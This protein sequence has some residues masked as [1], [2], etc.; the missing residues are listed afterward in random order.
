MC[1]GW[2]RK[3]KTLGKRAFHINTDWLNDWQIVTLKVPRA[4][5]KS[6]RELTSVSEEEARS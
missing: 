4:R 3:G 1:I 2:K 6:G 5:F